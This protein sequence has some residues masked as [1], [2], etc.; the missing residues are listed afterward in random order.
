MADA[1]RAGAALRGVLRSPAAA[2]AAARPAAAAPA[3]HGTGAHAGARTLRGAGSAARPA[4]DVPP[5]PAGDALGSRPLQ[6]VRAVDP[7]ALHAEPL[8]RRAGRHFA[9]RPDYRRPA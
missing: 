5:L 6:P 3:E 4:R 7:A 8:T 1:G 2:P 9:G